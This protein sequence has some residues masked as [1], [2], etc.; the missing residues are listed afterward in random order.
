V[1][2]LYL[3]IATQNGQL[4]SVF[5]QFWRILKSIVSQTQ[6]KGCDDRRVDV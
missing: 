2:A 3:V 5:T 4:G 1:V 6:G